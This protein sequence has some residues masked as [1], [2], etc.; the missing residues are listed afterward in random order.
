VKLTKGDKLVAVLNN[1]GGKSTTVRFT[2]K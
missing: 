2:V 1:V